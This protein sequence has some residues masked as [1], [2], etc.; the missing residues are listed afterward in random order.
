MSGRI[1]RYSLSVSGF[2]KWSG[3]IALAAVA[4]QPAAAETA[5]SLR[6]FAEAVLLADDTLA[7]RRLDVDI[8]GADL[9]G[10]R[11]A[12]EP[13]AFIS[14]RR[15]RSNVEN[16]AQERLQ[17]GLSNSFDSRVTDF[18]AGLASR[19]ET[20][21]DV[22]FAYRIDR[23][24]NNLQPQ[25]LYG[26]EFRSV[27][28]V[29]VT[30]PLLR[31]AGRAFNRAPINIAEYEERLAEEI[32][33]LSVQQRLADAVGSYIQF[34][35]ATERVELLRSSL[36]V[37]DQLV[38]TAQRMAALGARPGSAIIEA[39]VFR[40]TRRQQLEQARQDMVEARASMRSL[41]LATEGRLRDGAAP[42]AVQIRN[43]PRIGDR[44][45]TVPDVESMRNTAFERRSESRIAALRVARDSIRISA[46][47]NQMLP[48]LDITARYDL[49]GLSDS[50]QS[51]VGRAAR[52]PNRVWGVGIELRVPLQGNQRARADHDAARLRRDQSEL[53]LVAARQRIANEVE[54]TREAAEGAVRQLESQ[55]ALVMSQRELLRSADVQAEGGRMSG[56]ELQRR[57]LELLQAEEQLLSRKAAAYRARFAIAFTSGRLAEELERD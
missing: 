5:L 48:Q 39:V 28:G 12:F 29:S 3:L 41:L 36:E 27:V 13:S 1:G 2:F 25:S 53:A 50:A 19:T 14:G 15:D 30:Q 40:D 9:R 20:G 43:V 55:R 57:R 6:A 54:S 56:I 44:A 23:Y 24:R 4:W 16:T 10:A 37:A 34:Q 46:A 22:E 32:F 47:E 52:G 8:A 33:R 31:G 51:S 17:R 38:R 7:G 45:L 21:G 49:D 26:R 35:E 18:K 11:G 42:A